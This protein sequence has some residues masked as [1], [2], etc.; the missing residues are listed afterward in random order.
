MD[1]RKIPLLLPHKLRLTNMS[2]AV[3]LKIP[4]FLGHM[5]K[6]LLGAW[7]YINNNPNVKEKRFF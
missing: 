7:C 5:L 4:D 6:A 3:K 2:F 1:L